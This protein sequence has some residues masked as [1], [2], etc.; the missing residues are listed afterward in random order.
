MED[1]LQG[2]AVTRNTVWDKEKVVEPSAAIP[3]FEQQLNILKSVK[4]RFTSSLFD[5]KQLVQADY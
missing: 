5:I 2:L 1:Y 4:Q 3:K